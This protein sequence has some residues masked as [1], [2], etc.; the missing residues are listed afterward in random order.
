MT[1][2]SSFAILWIKICF[3][4][5]LRKWDE[6]KQIYIALTFV[7]QNAVIAIKIIGIY[8]SLFY[9]KNI[10]RENIEAQICENL[11]IF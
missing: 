9:K 11:K 4:K 5:R 3:T 8:T 1:Y 2:S 10:Y 7:H 6:P